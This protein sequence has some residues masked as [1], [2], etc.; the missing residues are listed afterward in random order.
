VAWL[1]SR[2]RSAL[3]APVYRRYRD[4]RVSRQVERYPNRVVEHDYGGHRLR[5]SI[6]D[7]LG[8]GWYDRDHPAVPEAVFL[9]ERGLLARGMTVFDLGAHQG[10]IALML[11]RDVEPGGRVVA[12]EAVPHNAAVARRNVTLNPAPVTVVNAAVADAPGEAFVPTELNAQVARQAGAGLVR[13]P[14]VTID[15]LAHEHGPP[16]VVMIDVEGYELAALRGAA[17]TLASRRAAWIVELHVGAGL[18]DAGG[19]AREVLARFDGY[20]LFAA[21]ADAEPHAPLALDSPLLRRRIQVVA[22]PRQ[23]G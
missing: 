8:E 10:V 5:I 4:W 14:A 19:S 6:E 12:V 17:R 15:D 18:E 20:D 21:P 23:A 13:V 2:I 1:K 22:V 11:A 7:G 9:R 16:D 3:P